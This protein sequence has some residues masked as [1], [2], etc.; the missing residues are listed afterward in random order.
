MRPKQLCDIVSCWC[1]IIFHLAIQQN[2]YV[3]VCIYVHTYG[4]VRII[5]LEMYI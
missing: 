2:I 4:L 3:H 1:M 5:G